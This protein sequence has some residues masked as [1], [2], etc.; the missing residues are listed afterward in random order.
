MH[1]DPIAAGFVLKEAKNQ[2]EAQAG[3]LVFNREGFMTLAIEKD[4]VTD[5]VS[6]DEVIKQGVETMILNQLP[7]FRKFLA[8]SVFK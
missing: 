6:R 1:N 3:G 7:F 4:G 2:D 5:F 8:I